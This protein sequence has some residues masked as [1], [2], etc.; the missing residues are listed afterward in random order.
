MERR[1]S[2]V[3]AEVT[4]QGETPRRD[5]ACAWLRV[6]ETGKPPLSTPN[7][8]LSTLDPRRETLD[9]EP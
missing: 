4:F 8:F 2:G 7:P 9:F 1:W 6:Q 5:P 3:G